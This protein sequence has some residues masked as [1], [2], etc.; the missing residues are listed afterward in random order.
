MT[1]TNF[2]L[3]VG[4]VCLSASAWTLADNTQDANDPTKERYCDPAQNADVLAKIRGY[5]KQIDAL[6]PN[7]PQ[8]IAVIQ[9]ITQ[10]SHLLKCSY[11]P[12][13]LN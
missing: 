4:V 8:K 2:A 9:K 6:S 11:R 1:K 3:W 5:E 13:Q 10:A 12:I 7:D